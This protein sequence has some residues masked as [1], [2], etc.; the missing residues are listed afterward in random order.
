MFKLALIGV[1]E[2]QKLVMV[3]VCS[4]EVIIYLTQVNL[5]NDHMLKLHQVDFLG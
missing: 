4:S 3:A 1:C 5:A 2:L